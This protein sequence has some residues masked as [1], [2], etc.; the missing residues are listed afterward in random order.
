MSPRF[1]RFLAAS[2]IAGGLAVVVVP[3]ILS[4]QGFTVAWWYWLLLW[5]FGGSAMAAGFWLWHDEPRGW[6]LSRLL[7]ALQIVQFRTSTLGISV[8]A[9]FQLRLVVSGTQFTVG[10][11]F[12]GSLAINLGQAMP[13]FVSINF[14]SAYAIYALSRSGPAGGRGAE[15]DDPAP[16]AATITQ[17]V[18]ENQP[19][20]LIS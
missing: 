14:F 19:D 13:W 15:H 1:R 12:E 6:K 20:R 3:V 5:S 2:E 8:L 17:S 4:R 11:A 18:F 9:G 7:Q 16:A 10:P